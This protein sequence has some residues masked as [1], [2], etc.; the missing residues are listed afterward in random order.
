[1]AGHQRS[2]LSPLFCLPGEKM[3]LFHQAELVARAKQR[4]AID[5]LMR[6]T[7][8]RRRH[9][10][11][12]G[13]DTIDITMRC[14]AEIFSFQPRELIGKHLYVRGQWQRSLVDDAL[15]VLTANYLLKTNSCLM[16][17]G[18]NIGTQSVYLMKSGLFRNIV[19]VEAHP[20]NYQLLLRNLSQNG[21]EGC[22]T[23]MN[24]AVAES[25]GVIELFTSSDNEGGHSAVVRHRDGTSIKV[26]SRTIHSIM[27]EA[28][29]DKADVG[30]FWIDIEGM[31]FEILRSI[32][33]ELGTAIPVLLEFSPRF[34]GVEKTRAFREFLETNFRYCMPVPLSGAPTVKTLTRDFHANGS[35][36]D[37]LV[38][39]EN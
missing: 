6:K 15:A 22:S 20:A 36:H 38:F 28:G 37:I 17:L 13:R 34:Y 33:A 39:N 31:E 1:M 23:A 8:F 9:Q 14:G 12:F 26:P 3:R 2:G 25:D 4:Q 19:A 29:V 7:W 32:V 24:V 11:F 21:C 18:A 27:R 5:W 35:Q 10:S 16:E 30:F